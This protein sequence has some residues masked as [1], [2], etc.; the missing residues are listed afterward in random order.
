MKNSKRKKWKEKRQTGG[1]SGGKTSREPGGWQSSFSNHIR[2]CKHMHKPCRTR[3]G[4]R[5]ERKVHYFQYCLI[6][7]RMELIKTN[8][9]IL[10][11]TKM[12]SFHQG[13][14]EVELDTKSAKGKALKQHQ[15]SRRSDAVERKRF[16][17]REKLNYGL[18][19][20]E[21]LL[22]TKQKNLWTTGFCLHLCLLG[23]I[24]TVWSNI[25]F[26]P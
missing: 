6:K 10:K 23:K 1:Q 5:K 20:C 15:K 7:W 8:I 22:C 19:M 11:K 24:F 2:S 3:K 16:L 17:I 25:A 13:I 9:G 12:I 26:G 14:F 18:K 4:N 21:V